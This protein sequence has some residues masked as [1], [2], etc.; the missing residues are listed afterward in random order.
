MAR[1]GC[2]AAAPATVLLP[3][4][5]VSCHDA[6]NEP[7]FIYGLTSG[8]MF[9]AYAPVVFLSLCAR[10]PIALHILF[11]K[12]CLLGSQQY[13]PPRTREGVSVTSR[14]VGSLGRD[15][16]KT[17]KKVGIG[18]WIVI[19]AKASNSTLIFYVKP[20]RE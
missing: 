16:R 11:P 6:M 19:A 18:R 3:K 5:L 14:K 7:P 15:P 17:Q 2:N 8:K 10:L 13:R 20:A 1:N 9:S 4:Q 12:L